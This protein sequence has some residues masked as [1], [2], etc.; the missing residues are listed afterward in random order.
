MARPRNAPDTPPDTKTEA[1]PQGDGAAAST[2]EAPPARRSASAPARPVVKAPTVPPRRS[3]SAYAQGRR[4]NP[5]TQ[6]DNEIR[7]KASEWPNFVLTHDPLRWGFYPQVGK[8]LPD[9]GKIRLVPGI[10]RVN[11]KGNADAALVDAHKAGR[12]VIYDKDVPEGYAREYDMLGGVGYLCRWERV[13]VTGRAA[14]IE[15]DWD[16]YQAF[17]AELLELDI[18]APPDE[19]AISNL[20]ESAKAMIDA[21]EGRKHLDRVANEIKMYQAQIVA[22]DA[23]EAVEGDE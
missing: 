19:I 10:G 14:R 20:R 9:F 12:V 15:V 17:V 16:D 6:A 11:A 1:P 5:A 23:L 21:C 7:I 22:C 2:V 4:V 8:I 18:I 3:A 13:K